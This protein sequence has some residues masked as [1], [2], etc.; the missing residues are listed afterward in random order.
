MELATMM[1]GLVSHTNRKK[2]GRLRRA[3]NL[4]RRVS[5]SVPCPVCP[6]LPG[7]ILPDPPFPGGVFPDPPFPGPLFPGGFFPDPSTP[8]P[9]ELPPAEFLPDEFLNKRSPDFITECNKI[10]MDMLWTTR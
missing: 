8:D 1:P 9:D 2:R 3:A 10:L 5:G 6:F 4:S 7:G